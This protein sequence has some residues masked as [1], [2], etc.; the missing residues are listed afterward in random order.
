[1]TALLTLVALLLT[2]P[3]ATPQ[4]VHDLTAALDAAVDRVF[5]EAGVPGAIVGLSI[6]GTVEYVRTLG[7]GDTAA[8]TPMSLDD[9]TR[10]GSVTKTFTGTAVLQ[11]VDQGRIRLSDPISRYVDGVPSGGVVTLDM[12]G[13]MRSGLFNYTTDE[14]F[15]DRYLEE[16]GQGPDAAA[17]TPRELVDIAFAHP[18]NFAPDTEFEYSNTNT[19]LLGMVIERVT[20]QRLGDYLAQHVTGPLGLTHTSFPANGAMPQPYTHGYA[21]T[22]DGEPVDTT[23]WNPSV[24][25]AAGAM[26]STYRDL[27]AWAP[28]VARG[29]LLLPWTHRERTARPSEAAPGIGYMFA[30]ADFHGWIGHN[31]DIPGYQTVAV[32]LPERDATLVVMVNSDVSESASTKLAE[33]VTTVATPG[34][35]YA[36]PEPA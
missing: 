4:P 15:L 34:N 3:V 6:P 29:A 5:A 33:A 13:R 31:G 14:Q 36:L 8:K 32:Y 24:A 35:V 7:E 1:M 16:G 10:I 22:P 27:R 12:L 23:L 9:H 20:G 28:A 2:A 19:V 25:W 18:L 21:E 26:I 30:L 17:F 11:L